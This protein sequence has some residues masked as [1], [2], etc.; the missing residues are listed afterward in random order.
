M[1]TRR[2]VH[3]WTW[4][5]RIT[6]VLFAVLI[7]LAGQSW[8]PWFSGSLTGTRL[9]DV[10]VFTDPLA[11]LEVSLAT[12]SA[13]LTLL[14]GAVLLIG[15][16]VVMGPVFCAW[17]CP[18][19]LILD[20]NNVLRQGVQRGLKPLG[21]RLPDWRA[22][23]ALRYLAL[24]FALA[25]SVVIQIPVFQTL[26][27]INAL[28]WLLAFQLLTPI[29]LVV[30]ILMLIELAAPRIWCRALC[31]V[32][33]VYSLAGRWGQFRVRVNPHEAGKVP[34]RQCS[35][36]CPMGIRVMEDYT[37]PLRASIDHP[38]C[39]RCGTCVDACQR[40]VLW[41]GFGSQP[42]E[43]KTCGCP[44]DTNDSPV[45]GQISSSLPVVHIQTRPMRI[46]A[47]C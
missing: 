46:E 2:R 14:V 27:P 4:A 34:C 23:H 7:V 12:R 8:F 32:G 40:D 5:R 33:A 43:P 18:L 26:S 25:I 20:L 15:F 31:P 13:H 6:A 3:R 24:G 38:E 1:N 16:A 37:L 22:P 11:A 42:P 10:L 36:A 30:V 9:L 29:A 19:G 45:E 44:P 21:L 35:M 47:L 41:L 17:V 39:T 28:G